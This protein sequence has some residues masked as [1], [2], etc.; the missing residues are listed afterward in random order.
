MSKKYVLNLD[1]HNYTPFYTYLS[2]YL[3]PY[4]L[5]IILSLYR[6]QSILYILAFVIDV[7]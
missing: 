7:L 6:I 1:L 4:I 2:K 3:T 5:R